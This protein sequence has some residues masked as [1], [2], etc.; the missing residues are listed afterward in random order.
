MLHSFLVVV[1][2]ALISL[3]T[4]ACA[5]AQTQDPYQWLEDIHAP[6]SLDWV[7][8]RN[9]KATERLEKD[10]RFQKSRAEA[11]AILAAKDRIIAPTREGNE[12]VEFY[13]DA[14]HVRGILRRTPVAAYRAGTPQWETL[15]DVDALG[16]AENESWVWHGKQC[17]PPKYD[18]CLVLLSRGGKDAEVI[19]EWDATQRKFVE[20]GF[21]LPEAK[22]N[23]TWLDSDT[24]LV[25]TDFG[26]GTLTDSGYP[27]LIK[28]WKRGTPLSQAE[29][30]FEAK[31]ED[32]WTYPVVSFRPEGKVAL[33]SRGRNFYESDLYWY[34][35]DG[36]LAPLPTT[37]H[38]GFE[39]VFQGQVVGSLK[40]DVKIA[41]KA[42]VAGSVIAFD[43]Q[44]WSASLIYEPTSESGYASVAITQNRLLLTTL[45]N[46]RSKLFDARLDQGQWK[47]TN[48]GLP[49]LG[50]LSVVDA[51]AWSDDAFALYQSFFE[52]TRLIDIQV[53][54]TQT[55]KTLP[56]RFDAKGM[57]AEQRWAVSRDGTR[58]P[59]F[60][61]TSRTSKGPLPTLLYGYG[62]FEVS[63]VPVYAG[64]MGKLW[65]EKGGA[66]ALANIRGG[67]EF[68]PRWHQ[69]ALLENRQRAFDD[70]VA[71]AEALIQ[72]GVTS[73]ERLAIQGGSNGGLLV[74]ATYTQRPD[75]FRAV[76]CQVPLLDMLRYHLLLAG[77]SW[78]AEYGNPDDAR[79]R[80]VIL[81]YSPYQNLKAG[82]KYPEVFFMTS[83]EDDRVHPG[84]ARKMA[85][86]M[87]E[88]GHPYLYF[89]NMEGGHGAAADLEQRARMQ[90][91]SY[92]FLYQTLMDGAK[93]R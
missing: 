32:V 72:S 82:M 7:K 15:F 45:E 80:D 13:Q 78:M 75:L 31:K 39:G 35:P 33:I 63:Q 23:V 17:I 89:E 11:K 58:I 30:L 5:S 54:R 55:L 3:M 62:G 93:A 74:G 52:P 16:K 1:F 21:F 26:P 77:A 66:Y 27:R 18:R 8:A 6:Q 83:T 64:V 20:G 38:F 12:I 61:L 48:L 88:M 41:G 76:V 40:K 22:T 43:L 79:M 29:L 81:R 37:E 65:L 50:T 92:T 9:S 57:K 84:H 51:D 68:G 60:L 69:A 86:R 46:V 59:Y 53:E 56:A 10:P 67:G 85:A 42:F 19:R 36:T 47:L 90:A 70:F 73:P 14:Q 44:K 28:V 2:P 24:L 91:L 49:D 4:T 71:V 34:R 25:G 87:E